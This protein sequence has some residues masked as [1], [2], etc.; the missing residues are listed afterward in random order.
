MICHEHGFFAH[1]VHFVHSKYHRS[2]AD[3]FARSP[4]KEGWEI[5]NTLLQVVSM[6]VR[7]EGR[8]LQYGASQRREARKLVSMLVRPEG[9]T[10]RR[11]NGS[12]PAPVR[13]FNARPPRRTD[14]TLYLSLYGA[15]D[16][17]FNA[18][19]PRRTDATHATGDGAEGWRHVSMLVRPE[20]RTLR[21]RLCRRSLCPL[22]FNARPPRRTDATESGTRF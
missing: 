13:G 4:T 3:G 19:P 14:A 5:E 20:G 21:L 6:L 2:K 11:S 10:L 16:Q 1:R 18:R 15:V 8:T 12:L 7:P 22:G 17:S 9:R